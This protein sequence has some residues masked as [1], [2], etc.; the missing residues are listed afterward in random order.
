M[1][2]L[3]ALV[4]LLLQPIGAL[5]AQCTAT[6]Q[7]HG[8]SPVTGFP[9]G[10]GTTSVS[11]TSTISAVGDLVAI[12]VWCFPIN[13][14]SGGCT[15]TSVTLGAQSATQTTVSMNA[16]PGTIGT[17]GSGQG[18]IYYILSAAAS[19]SQTLGFSISGGNQQLQVT[20]MDFKPSAACHFTHHLDSPLGAGSNVGA[21]ITAPSISGV[22]GD[23]LYNFTITSTHM[24]D[25][26]GSPWV[27]T[28]WQPGGCQFQN[29][30]DTAVHLLSAPAGTTSN[31]L[32]TLHASDSW[33]ALITSFSMSSVTPNACPTG[34]N[35]LNASG[36]LV[37]LASL[38]VTTCSYI[39]ANGA[40]TNTG[41]DEA[42]P[43]LHA[44]GMPN[45][46]S[47]CATKWDA[48]S[49]GATG[50]GLIFKG[51]DTWHYGNNA[52]SPY[53]GI[54]ASGNGS[55]CDA[56]NSCGWVVGSNHLGA[57][58]PWIGT[59]ANPLYFGV[60]PAW[61]SGGSWTRPTMNGDNATSVSSVGSCTFDQGNF[62]FLNAWSRSA[63]FIVDNFEW[64]G[65][66]WSGTNK[67]AS[68]ADIHDH[69]NV[70][71]TNRH[72]QNNYF[73][74]WTH[75]TFNCPST[76]CNG[77][78]VVSGPSD[79]TFGTGD[80]IMFNVIDG[81]DTDQVSGDAITFG[82]FDIHGN[83]F[84]HMANAIITNNTHTLHDNLFEFLSQDADGVS[85]TNVAEFNVEYAGSE[86]VYNNLV[87][88]NFVTGAGEF[89]QMSPATGQ[90]DYYFNNVVYS[91]STNANWLDFCGGVGVGSGCGS[92]GGTINIFANTWVI[93]FSGG[94]AGGPGSGST[95][96]FINNHCIIPG[97]G[98][99]SSCYPSQGGTVNATTNTYQTPAQATA[100]G[101]TAGETFAYSPTSAGN[102]TVG[103]GTNEQ[104]I[105]NTLL[106]SADQ[107]VQ[108]AG[109][110]CQSDTGY[111][112][113]YN[114]SA[115]VHT[116]TCP[117]RTAIARP[118]S[119]T[120][121][122]GAYQFQAGTGVNQ[123]GACNETQ[124]TSPSVSVQAAHVAGPV[125]NLATFAALSAQ[126]PG[127]SSICR[128]S[129]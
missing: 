71:A 19:G 6:Q 83:Y 53:T 42:H 108:A 128:T 85:H 12:S 121:D 2:K 123:N 99:G 96:N 59:V 10:P 5:L 58:N 74:G 49:A 33:Q 113:T 17:P 106:A 70:T 27:C 45:C 87:R 120:W 95:A 115:G 80:T 52:L 61:F 66:C 62:S 78:T 63:N 51:G 107:L 9:S 109:T 50:V 60:D 112:C 48:L 72:I 75:V 94:A 125:E 34:A 82:G 92:S 25:P 14:F 7:N 97:G 35:Y 67:H 13:T 86:T 20:Y 81:S 111:S 30:V 104:S 103:T 41:A 102:A 38:G 32:N 114:S 39:A 44:P 73:H 15:P 100:Q 54:F 3:F 117:A 4:L 31:N 118:I 37:T 21:N 101:Y 11:M 47:A 46:A 68:Y 90:T 116:M 89:F 55:L 79:Q 43:W 29:S 40:D 8:D 64:T 22:T 69:V 23:L 28:I 119:A 105:C 110:A 127:T 124:T 56:G 129:H 24:T 65:L 16:D 91:M 88:N 57:G 126:R 77:L 26:V 84:G 1:R 36:S 93:P 18:R 76:N 98:S 122:V